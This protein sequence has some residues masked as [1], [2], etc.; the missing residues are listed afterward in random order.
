MGK[1]PANN[2]EVKKRNRL[3][4]LRRILASGT[5]SQT[6]LSQQLALSWPTILQNVRELTELGLV[7][8]AGQYEST[9]GR[10]AK[11]YA[12]VRNAKVAAGVN[13]TRTHVSC[14]LVN[15]TGEVIDYVHQELEFSFSESYAR[16]L[17]E[18]VT[19][20]IRESE[21]GDR[22]L[23]VGIS[24]PG[25][26]SSQDC[27]MRSH[28][29][30]LE[31]VP[32]QFF[33]GY[34]PY[35]CFFLNEASAAAFAEIYDLNQPRSLVYISLSNGVG[36]A[37]IYDGLIYDGK[38]QRAAEFGHMTLVPDGRTCYCG[39]RGCVDSYCSAQVLSRH[40]EGDLRTFFDR[41]AAGE[42]E[43]KAVW[44]EYLDNLAIFVNN[45]HVIFDCDIIVGG[46]VGPHVSRWRDAFR[47]R[48]TE[49]SP[50]ETQASYFRSCRYRFGPAAVGAALTRISAYLNA[51]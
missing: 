21:V 18:I 2:M 13:I 33:A 7:E 43:I 26:V 27:L 10:R 51:L 40:T 34:I 14:A 6:E 23:G 45:L 32:T 19:S 41:L 46:V 48:L 35:P 5:I 4:T 9:G 50:F 44:N 42:P 11:A 3:S 31:N 15:L 38:N 47:Q 22:V 39:R 29:L 24:L 8:E 16:E 20:F 28:I 37:I 17:G 12:A 25:T 1:S 36:G 49:R 30:D